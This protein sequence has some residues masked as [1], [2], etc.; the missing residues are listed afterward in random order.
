MRPAAWVCAL[1]GLPPAASFAS[2]YC[3]IRCTCWAW[4]DGQR[5]TL[6][7]RDRTMSARPL[8]TLEQ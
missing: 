4:V 7:A 1:L 8:E 6:S 3:M 2:A 5:S